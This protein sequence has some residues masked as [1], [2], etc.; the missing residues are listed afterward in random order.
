MASAATALCAE[1]VLRELQTECFGRALR[2]LAET[3]S[4]IDIARDW[5]RNG[6]PHGAVVIAERQTRGRGRAGRAWASP[7]GGLWMSILTRPDVAPATAGRL[8]IGLAL[9]AAEAVEAAS[10]LAIGVKWPNDL[11]AGGRKL[12]GVLVATGTAGQRVSTAILSLGINVNVSPGDLPQA[13]RR[14]ATS[15]LVET[16]RSHRIGA[17]AAHVLGALERTWAGIV[18]EADDLVGR[19]R[20]RDALAGREVLIQTAGESLR[21]R[22]QGIDGTGALVLMTG[23]DERKVSA[24]EATLVGVA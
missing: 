15:L 2:M 21:G 17:L 7:A 20:R 6:G 18:E 24:G 11:M 10:G 5:L 13:L 23:G 16:G 1:A 12:G 19:W 22:A 3:G 8:G 9:A 14:S 4:T